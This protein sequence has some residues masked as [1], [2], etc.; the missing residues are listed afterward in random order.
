VKKTSGREKDRYREPRNIL[1]ATSVHIHGSEVHVVC[2][3]PN[4]ANLSRYAFAF[5][6][7]QPAVALQSVTR[8]QHRFRFG[9]LSFLCEAGEAIIEQGELSAFVS[10]RSLAFCALG[11][12]VKKLHPAPILVCSTGFLLRRSR[13][14]FSR[15][16]RFF[17]QMVF[18]GVRAAPM[19]ALTAFSVGRDS[20][21]A[22]CAF[23]RNSRSGNVHSPIW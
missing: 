8:G 13:V 6:P 18:I 20:S 17:R 4:S 10:A 19:V 5:Q 14:N 11:R 7:N 12:Q 23:S 16:R 1:P 21:N 15:S 3:G 9:A 2:N 22:G